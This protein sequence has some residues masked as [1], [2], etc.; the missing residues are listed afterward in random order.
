MVNSKLGVGVVVGALVAGAT[1]TT[2]RA[3]DPQPDPP[4]FGVVSITPDQ[5]IRL[6]AVCSERGVGGLPP[7]P[8]RAELMLH[9]AAG[10][11]LASQAVWL[12]P[13]QSTFLD[14][15]IGIRTAAFERIGI[16][17]CVIPDPE[18]GR[19]LPT[20]EVFDNATGQ[21]AFVVNPVTPRLSFIKGQIGDAR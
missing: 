13:G 15:R 6:N 16:V 21:T 18:R 11:V 10:N 3:F 2:L 4:A 19:I 12:K 9:D 14:Y 17:P 20:A 7:D 1:W 8:C 5:T